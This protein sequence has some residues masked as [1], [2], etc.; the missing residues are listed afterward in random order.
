[1]Q[2]MFKLAIADQAMTISKLRTQIEPQLSLETLLKNME[3]LAR[4]SLIEKIKEKGETL[5]TLQ[6]VIKKYAS[7]LKSV[8]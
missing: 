5:F 8:A 7:K 3:S 1:M 6:P 2:I 4:R